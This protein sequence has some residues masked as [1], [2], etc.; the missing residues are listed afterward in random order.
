MTIE[1]QSAARPPLKKAH[2]LLF[3]VPSLC[4]GAAVCVRPSGR[5]GPPDALPRVHQILYDD[6]DFAAYALRGLND[7]LGRHAGRLDAPESSYPD[8]YAEALRE[9][10]ALS[11]EYYLEYPHAALLLFKVPHLLGPISTDVPVSLLDGA[12]DDI[13]RHLPQ[14]DQTPVWEYFHR[15]A[16]SYMLMMVAFHAALV[17]VL[18]AGY[19]SGGGLAYRG[20]LLILPGVLFFALNRF[21]V[22][23]ALLTALGFACLGRGRISASAMFLAAGTLIKIYPLFL[24]PIVVRHLITA[25]SPRIVTNWILAYLVTIAAF[26]GP[27]AYVWG[28]SEVVAPYLVQLSRKA[29]GMNAYQYLVPLEEIRDALTGNGLIGRGFRLG[30]L[31]LVMAFLLVRP[32]ADLAGVLRR[33]AVVLI[34]FISLSV[35]YSPQWVLWLTPLLL[36]LAVRQRKLILLIAGLD[37]VTWGQWPIAWNLAE[38]F[39]MEDYPRDVIL[40]VLAFARFAIL[41][42]I[43]WNVLR[44]DRAA[45]PSTAAVVLP[46]LA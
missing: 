19:L 29:E 18:A 37:L 24:V 13:V 23:P 35:F 21:D 6:Y 25:H 16:T 7:F 28:A 39:G 2:L 36:P 33:G 20:F 8:D 22:V 4:F 11:S 40:T 45:E 3:I 14:G 31:T 27:A 43:V 46:A 42:L 9:T 10:R 32:I 17:V 44:A 38:A 15:A 30:S 41:G 34:V 12:H 1:P 5:L 26:I